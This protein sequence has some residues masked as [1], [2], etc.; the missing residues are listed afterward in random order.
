MAGNCGGGEVGERKLSAKL[1]RVP[2]AGNVLDL[3]DE[4]GDLIP[5]MCDS[6]WSSLLPS[7]MLKRVRTRLMFVYV[8]YNRRPSNKNEYLNIRSM[9]YKPRLR[10]YNKK[11]QKITSINFFSVLWV[12]NIYF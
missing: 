12:L 11:K 2:L 5:F 4:C 3:L 7:E 10:S 8:I 6:S 9:P 1:D